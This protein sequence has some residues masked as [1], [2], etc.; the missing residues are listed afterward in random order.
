MNSRDM[1]ILKSILVPVSREIAETRVASGGIVF[2][3]HK[4]GPTSKKPMKKLGVKVRP[5]GT[6]VFGLACSDAAARSGMTS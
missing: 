6:V 1:D 3:V 4:P 5:K 2:V